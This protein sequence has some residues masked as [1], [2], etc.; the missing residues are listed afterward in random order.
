MAHLDGICEAG[1]HI[2]IQR[3]EPD[4]PRAHGFDEFRPPFLRN[5]PE[6]ALDRKEAFEVPLVTSLRRIVARL[7]NELKGGF[8][9]V[10]LL[11]FDRG[12]K[13]GITD[14]VERIGE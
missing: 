14:I 13:V 9:I 5:L 12:L 10:P 3:I 8:D 4:T 7:A 11:A 1:E 6:V 2:C